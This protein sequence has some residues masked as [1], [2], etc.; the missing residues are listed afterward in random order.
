MTAAESEVEFA[1]DA[2]VD[3]LV[4]FDAADVERAKAIEPSG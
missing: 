1:V 4:V 2:V 3:D